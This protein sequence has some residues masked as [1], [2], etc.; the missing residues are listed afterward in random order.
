MLNNYS[1]FKYIVL[2]YFKKNK[3]SIL[4]FLTQGATRTLHMQ[5]LLVI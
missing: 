3:I 1:K 2:Y 4:N 5:P